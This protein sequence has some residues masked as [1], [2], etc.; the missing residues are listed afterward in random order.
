M[1]KT[2]VSI[3][4][5]GQMGT[6]IGKAASKQHEVIFFDKD[7]SRSKEASKRFHAKYE[8]NL[9]IV[10]NSPIIILAVAGDVV[11]DSIAL[12]AELFQALANRDFAHHP[13]LEVALVAEGLAEPDN[14]DH[15]GGR[16]QYRHR[17]RMGWLLLNPGDPL[18]EGNGPQHGQ[19]DRPEH[20]F[21]G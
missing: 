13:E 1:K 19:S 15:K 8:N 18:G 4:G 11:I 21:T 7:S 3:I 9:P 17:G 20:R 10:L 6:Q 16:G 12:R 2:K 14:R 5:A